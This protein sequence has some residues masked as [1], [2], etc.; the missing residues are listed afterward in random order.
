MGAR[1]LRWQLQRQDVHAGRCH[2][3]T[4]AR[5]FV[6]LTAVVDVAS[7]RVL[8]HKV[9]IT[10]EACH[11]REVIEQAFRAGASPTSSTP[12]QAASSRPASLP[13]RCWARAVWARAVS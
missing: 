13:T 6:S 8:A 11:A 3:A 4:M 9:A 7:R 5:S 10:L 12:T 2:I 1:L